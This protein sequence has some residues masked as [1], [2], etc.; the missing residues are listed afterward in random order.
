MSWKKLRRQ[1][2]IKNAN[3]TARTFEHIL[4]IALVYS[5]LRRERQISVESL[6][7]AI[8][9]GEWLQANTLRI[10]S[11]TG[12]DA[13]GRAE[14]SVIDI[15]RRSQ[16]RVMFRRDLQ[17]AASKKNI[18]AEVFNRVIKALEANDIIRCASTRTDAGRTRSTVALLPG[19]PTRKPA[20]DKHSS[21]TCSQDAGGQG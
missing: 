8:K 12:L 5:V 19:T 18:N 6:A 9:L 10:F 15:L 4:K 11:D 14:R 3:L 21:V 17:Q 13:I 7:V 20:S 16:G 2:D 1:S